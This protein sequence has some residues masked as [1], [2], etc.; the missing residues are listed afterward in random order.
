MICIMQGDEVIE[1]PMRVWKDMQNQCNYIY[2]ES[3]KKDPCQFIWHLDNNEDP[4]WT[5]IVQQPS[6]PSEGAIWKR[7]VLQSKDNAA[8]TQLKWHLCEWKRLMELC[9]FTP[10][11]EAVGDRWVLC[12]AEI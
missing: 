12:V 5:L 9:S 7:I 8:G 11:L 10:D 1:L 4:G 3:L 2:S 6:N